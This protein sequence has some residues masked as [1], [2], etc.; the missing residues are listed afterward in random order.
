MF[1]T[2]T[3]DTVCVH[4]S[5]LVLHVIAVNLVLGDMNLAKDARYENI[6]VMC[7]I[8]FM[9]CNSVE[10]KQYLNFAELLHPTFL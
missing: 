7:P 9:Y 1:V 4:P 5:L 3:Q 8:V 10:E 6:H 2:L